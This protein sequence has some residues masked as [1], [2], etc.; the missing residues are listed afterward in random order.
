[1]A[2]EN[3]AKAEIVQALTE[4]AERLWGAERARAAREN[5]REAAEY[6]WLIAENP[7]DD[8]EAPL[9]HP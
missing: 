6:V 5:I 8:D 7:P 3:A 4:R 9:F 1:M 2:D